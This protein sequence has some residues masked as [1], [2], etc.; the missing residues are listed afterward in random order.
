MPDASIKIEG[1]RYVITMDEERRI[2]RDGSVVI[3]GNRITQVGKSTEL[4]DVAAQRVIDASGMVLTPG[5][6]NGH[7]HISYAHA[8]RGIFPDSLLLLKSRP[9]TRP[10]ESASTPYHSSRTRLARHPVELV[11][12]E[13]P[14][15][16]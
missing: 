14:A 6:V 16:R 13:P 3:D 12:S 9:V 15:V 11:Q 1:A 8:T 5:M 10:R 4:A 7:M 2:I